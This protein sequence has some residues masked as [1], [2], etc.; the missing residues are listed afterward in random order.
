MCFSVAELFIFSFSLLLI[1]LILL[2]L[3]LNIINFFSI[4]QLRWNLFS[5]RSQLYHFLVLFMFSDYHLN[6]P[7]TFS[8]L[9]SVNMN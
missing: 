6:I 4:L 5:F 3:I 2:L 1:F 7:N 8:I 9:F